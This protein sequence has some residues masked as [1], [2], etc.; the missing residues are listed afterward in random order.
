MAQLKDELADSRLRRDEALAEVRAFKKQ[1][2]ELKQQH[3][4]DQRARQDEENALRA[5]LALLEMEQIPSLERDR[6][7]MEKKLEKATDLAR[8][9]HKDLDGERSV[10][11]GLMDKIGILKEENEKRKEERDGM[12]AQ[13]Q[14]LSEQ[15]Q[16]VLFTLSAQAQIAENGGAGGDVIIEQKPSANKASRISGNQGSRQTPSQAR[17]KR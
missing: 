9:L 12:Q 13:I 1:L 3:A 14:D 11:R 8:S 10:T 16:D 5:R 7:R 4:A 2:G 15:L 6:Q 17:R